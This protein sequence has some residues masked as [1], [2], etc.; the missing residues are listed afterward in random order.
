METKSNFQSQT[1]VEE[2]LQSLPSTYS[3]FMDFKTRCIGCFLQ[4][5]CTLQDVAD[6]YQIPFKKLTDELEK[7]VPNPI[8]LKGAPNEKIV[9]SL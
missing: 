5:F 2:V 1:T 6:I 8:I 9:Q 7:H 4:K 3:V